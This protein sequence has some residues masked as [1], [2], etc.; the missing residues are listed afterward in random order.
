M[1]YFISPWSLSTTLSDR[2]LLGLM[3]GIAGRPGLLQNSDVCTLYALNVNT[4]VEFFY[5][6][7]VRFYG[8]LLHANMFLTKVSLLDTNSIPNL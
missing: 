5:E 3:C 6:S 8:I 1:T 2:I 4:I 7:F